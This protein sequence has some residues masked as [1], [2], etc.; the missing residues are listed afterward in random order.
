[1]TSLR[2]ILAAVCAVLALTALPAGGQT[3]PA[4]PIKL[5]SPYAAG[6]A[7]DII[8]RLLAEK[9]ADT[10]GQPVIVENKPGAGSVVGSTA[11]V[12]SPPDGYTIMMADIAHGANPALHTA[13]PYDTLK[14]FAP[15]VLVAKLPS[16]LL[17]HPSVP[18]STAAELV[19]YV[20]AHPHQL[21]YSS[22]G[23][24][25]ANHLSA[26]VWKSE[27]GLDVAHVPYKGGGEAMTALLSGQV[28]ILFITLPASLP[29]IKA[30]K[31]KAL[32]VTSKERS[33]LLPDVPTL[34]ETVAP[35]FDVN[36]WIGVVAPAGT[37]PDVVGVL[38][39]AF[40]KTLALPAVRERLAA[41]GAN[42]QG[43][44][45]EEFDRFIREEVQR[46]GKIIKPDMRAN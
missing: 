14:D 23:F 29:H 44:T 26:E 42:P 31:V 28:Q 13:L 40:N 17:V 21:N 5:I 36:L 8:S 43:G 12:K 37:P 19:A 10:L 15:I 30:G 16:V 25:S 6:G 24:G 4:R 18:V 35:G 33:A 22:S 32:A 39:K 3:W 9:L 7:N 20:K 27:L 11:L 41:L 1:M 46:W 34:S 2:T 45:P 38:N